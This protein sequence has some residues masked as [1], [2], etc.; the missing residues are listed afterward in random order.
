VKGHLRERSPGHWAIVLETRDPQTGQ[1]KRRWH[2]FVGTK[3]E[4]QVKKA[5]LIAALSQGSYVE[6]SKITVAEFV[7]SR[8]NLWEADATISVRTAQRYRQLAENQI[9]PH[10]GPKPVQKLTRLDVEAWH[11]ALRNGG[12][13]PVPS[14]MP[15][16]SSVKHCAT[17]RSMALS[18]RTS[19]S[20][21]GRPRCPKAKWLLCETC[22]PF[23]P[24]YRARVFTFR[25]W[26]PSSPVCG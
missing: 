24:S 12:L 1:R 21:A 20:F 19:A 26:W 25:P 2:S 10:I 23:S 16:G 4:A 15:I 13:H 7:G 18:P 14:A 8:I 3:R 6:R 17:P 11:T 22:R 5:E 9:V